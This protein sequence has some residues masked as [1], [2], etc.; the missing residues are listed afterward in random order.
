M[1]C[2]GFRSRHLDYT[3]GTLDEATLVACERHRAE[4]RDCAAHDARVRRSL[5]V[6]HSVSLSEHRCDLTAR[7]LE[8]IRADRVRTERRR[9]VASWIGGCAACALAVATI[10]SPDTSA[11]TEAR[12]VGLSAAVTPVQS[13]V[14]EAPDVPAPSAAAVPVV[15]PMEPALWVDDSTDRQEHV[16][17]PMLRPRFAPS[18]TSSGFVAVSLLAP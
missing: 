1:D 18:A 2:Q 7:V 10:F 15:G 8:G 6:C 11:E 12:F 9:R 5:M 16:P 14:V 3:E 13:P 17:A 4:C